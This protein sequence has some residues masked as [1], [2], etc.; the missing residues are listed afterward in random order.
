MQRDIRNTPLYREAHALH[1][2]LRGPGAGRI[3]DA[4]EAHASPDVRFA[5]FTGTLTESLEGMTPA[6]RDAV[7][8]VDT[9]LPVEQL[10]TMEE[11][12]RG[13]TTRERLM[14]VMTGSFAILATL[15]A[16]IGLYGMVAYAVAQ[17]TP[18]IGLRMALGATRGSVRWMILRQVLVVAA[19]GTAIGLIAAMLLGRTAQ[20]L[21]FE[22]RFHDPIV[23]AGSILA[24]MLVAVAAGVVPAD[25]AAHVDPISALKY[26]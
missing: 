3:S 19:V 17:R 22:L 8:R 4:A 14:S 6:I 12:M 10:R 9:N 25:R 5:M 26:E 16:A 18:E 23:L 21:L 7:R 2:A 11:A 24:L 15:V 1:A 13:A 20:T